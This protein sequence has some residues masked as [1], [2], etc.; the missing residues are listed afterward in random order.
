MFTSP[1]SWDIQLFHVIHSATP[2]PPDMLVVA[3][4]LAD[5]PLVLTAVLLGLMV[6]FPRL[7]MRASASRAI[8]AAIVALDVAGLIGVA[9][10][11]PRP[12][13]ANIGQAWISHAAT[14]SFPSNHLTLQ[15]T[16]A[17]MLLLDRRTRPWGIVIALL[18]LPM[19]WARVY[20]GVHYPSDMMGALGIAGLI[21]VSGWGVMHFIE[22]RR[23]RLLNG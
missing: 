5:G 22:H 18:G 11:R 23:A 9:W 6:A 16:I 14:S 21:T 19:A 10:D 13:I 15:W 7:S 2:P 1:N 3:R 8:I 12:F 4:L 17:G 20:L